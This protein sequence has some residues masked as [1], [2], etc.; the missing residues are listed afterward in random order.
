MIL[1][2]YNLQ[3]YIL[4]RNFY[5]FLGDIENILESD[6]S[7][8]TFQNIDSSSP[9]N[10]LLLCEIN[11][12]GKFVFKQPK[13]LTNGATWYIIKES[14]F[15]QNFVNNEKIYITNSYW[16]DDNYNI[17]ILPYFE[18]FELKLPL[19]VQKEIIQLPKFLGEELAS[20]HSELKQHTHLYFKNFADN[21]QPTYQIFIRQLIQGYKSP[22]FLDEN[23]F[24]NWVKMKSPVPKNI[25]YGFLWKKSISEALEKIFS[26]SNESQIIHGDLKKENL[27]IDGSN[28]KFIDFESFS[29]G[30][31]AWDLACLAESYLSSVLFRN[32]LDATQRFTFFDNLITNYVEKAKLS[33]EKKEDIYERTL[34]FYAL[35]LLESFRNILLTKY[36]DVNL[37]IIELILIRHNEIS[38]GLLRKDDKTIEA[39]FKYADK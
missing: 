25:L 38:K 13:F 23:L 19:E 22:S 14:K 3:N 1:T 28:L 24:R 11:G 32:N 9:R 20:F 8:I 31:V 2:A 15:Y 29:L 5:G 10:T 7:K 21:F 36:I 30:D 39:I 27:L 4:Q 18:R 12:G 6:F 35:R 37:P 17:L 16:F 33:S 34:I 26:I